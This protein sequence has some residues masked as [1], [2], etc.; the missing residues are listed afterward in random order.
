MELVAAQPSLTTVATAIVSN[1][2][3]S[4]AGDGVDITAWKQAG[5]QFSRLLVA[6]ESDGTARTAAAPTGGQG[7]PE[8]WTFRKDSAG[9]GKWWI[10]A[11]L[12]GGVTANVPAAGGKIEGV[13]SIA[14]GDRLVVVATIAAGAVT[15]SFTPVEFDQQIVS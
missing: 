5:F 1:T 9:A 13:Q 4:A 6:L 10:V 15:Y 7:G 14:L 11:Y 12:N 2:L 3:P 8:L